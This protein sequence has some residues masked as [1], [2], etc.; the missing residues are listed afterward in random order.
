MNTMRCFFVSGLIGFAMFT[1][2]QAANYPCSGRKGGVSHCMG[3]YFVCNDGTVSQSKK[4]CSAGEHP[5][6]AKPLKGQKKP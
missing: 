2:A 4:I 1:T 5:P 6:P 3:Q